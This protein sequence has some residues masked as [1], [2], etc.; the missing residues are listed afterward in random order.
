MVKFKQGH[1]DQLALIMLALKLVW[2]NCALVHH[3]VETDDLGQ[4]ASVDVGIL[5]NRT[6][7]LHAFFVFMSY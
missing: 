4:I 6:L 1:T 5:L 7:V 2:I 3:N